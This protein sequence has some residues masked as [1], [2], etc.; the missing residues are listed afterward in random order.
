MGGGIS[1]TPLARNPECAPADEPTKDAWY[2]EEG[3]QTALQPEGATLQ[4]LRIL[5]AHI[6][7]YL[8]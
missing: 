6:H 4:Q 5:L 8:E 1:L 3:H 7:A 2:G